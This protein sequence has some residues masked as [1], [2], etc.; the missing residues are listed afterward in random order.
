MD[1]PEDFRPTAV[2]M[3]QGGNQIRDTD[4]GGTIRQVERVETRV[5]FTLEALG[6]FAAP[7][8]ID[9]PLSDWRARVL[10]GPDGIPR[11]VRARSVFARVHF[12]PLPDHPNYRD[13]IRQARPLA[14]PGNTRH[15]HVDPVHGRLSDEAAALLEEGHELRE[16]RAREFY[17]HGR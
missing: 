6:E 2:G 14:R 7:Q 5:S 16:D 1:S 13:Y 8:T 10:A 3:L 11:R 12:R 15:H 4:D 9:R 17:D